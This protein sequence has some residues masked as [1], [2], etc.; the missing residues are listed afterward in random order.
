LFFKGVIEEGRGEV[1]EHLVFE[2]TH[3]DRGEKVSGFSWRGVGASMTYLWGR[4]NGGVEITS[5]MTS[6]GPEDL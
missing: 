5:R 1:Q 3:L 4:R 6:D 2:G